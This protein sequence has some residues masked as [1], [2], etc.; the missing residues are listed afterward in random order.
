MTTTSNTCNKHN[1]GSNAKTTP[2]LAHL[3]EL[4]LEVERGAALP[5]EGSLVLLDHVAIG[6]RLQR[7]GKLRSKET[8]L[9]AFHTTASAHMHTL[10]LTAPVEQAP[11]STNSTFVDKLNQNEISFFP[12][13]F[14]RF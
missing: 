12:L 10:A 2:Q 6:V 9:N 5:E 11:C 8:G 4:C 1:S 7:W 14:H 13:I 3:P